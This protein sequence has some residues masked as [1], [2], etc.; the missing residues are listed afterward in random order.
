MTPLDLRQ[1]PPRSCYDKLDGLMLMPRTI[2]K[3][4]AS[5]PGGWTGCYHINGKIKGISGFLLERLGIHEA[6]LRD[7]ILQARD[8]DDVAAW[9][10]EHV[11]T[12]LYPSINA[13]LCKITPQHAE[14]P[15]YVRSAYAETLSANPELRTIVDIV[16]A[17][18]RRMFAQR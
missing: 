14:D 15:D 7:V 4:R 3:L 9:L 16:D 10:R 13:T 6:Q 12:S 5:L 8:D 18:D 1:R 11:D 17:D 2:D